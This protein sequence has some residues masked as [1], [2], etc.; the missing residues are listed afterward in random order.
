METALIHL[1]AGGP[2]ERYDLVVLD[3]PWENASARRSAHYPTLPSRNLLAIPMRRLLNPV[4]RACT[5][6]SG[7]PE[8]SP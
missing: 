2:D 3:P 7:L 8:A 4:R 5:V 6:S 1:A